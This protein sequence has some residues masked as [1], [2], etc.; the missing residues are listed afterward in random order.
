MRT[1]GTT[2]SVSAV[3]IDGTTDDSHILVPGGDF[4][5][6]ADFERVGD[7]LLLHGAYGRT[8][9]IRNYF[10]QDETPG[11]R[12]EGGAQLPAELIEQMAARGTLAQYAQ[13]GG[14]AGPATIGEIKEAAGSVTIRRANG[15]EVSAQPGDPIFLNDELVTGIDGSIGIEFVDG[16]VFSLTE[17]AR[18]VMNQ[19]VYQQAGAADSMLVSVLKGTFAFV[20]GSIASSGEDAMRVQTPVAMIGIRGTTVTGQVNIEGEIS[21]FTLLPDPD[22]NV[23][24]VIISNSTGVQ[25][26]T[27]AFEATEMTSFFTALSET[28]VLSPEAVQSVFGPTIERLRTTYERSQQDRSGDGANPDQQQEGEGEGEGQQPSGGDGSGDAPSEGEDS[29]TP[30]EQQGAVEVEEETETALETEEGEEVEEA[31]E[32]GEVAQATTE[33]EEDTDGSQTADGDEA[34]EDVDEGGVQQQTTG[35]GEPAD[36]GEEGQDVADEDGGEAEAGEDTAGSAPI[37]EEELALVTGI[38]PAAGGEAGGTGDT[39]DTGEESEIPPPPITLVDS[40]VQGGQIQA[41]EEADTS[42]VVT[43]GQTS[44]SSPSGASTT[45]ETAPVTSSS[46]DR[47]DDEPVNSPPSAVDDGGLSTGEGAT[48]AGNVLSNDV[49][50][51]GNVLCFGADP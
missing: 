46:D 36:A 27:Q 48:L 43:P 49:D 3:V 9:L 7:D 41:P 21:T 38:E 13:A 29:G 47:P 14:T 30:E 6:S 37:T 44:S 40:L 31:E 28:V 8:V 4:L 34:V 2:T 42:Q 15:D 24:R 39:G 11:L 1:S 19:L 12:T 35:P 45:T 51:D 26:L 5:L 10:G 20:T 23:G 16:T 22:G 25:I 50:P 18:M 33:G 32:E 17:D